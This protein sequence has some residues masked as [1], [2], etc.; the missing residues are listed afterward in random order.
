MQAVLGNDPEAD[1]PTTD[2]AMQRAIE[3]ARNVAD[4]KAT[5][6][7]QGEIGTGKARL[8][9]AIHAWSARR[10]G[11]LAIVSCDTPAGRCA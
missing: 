10:D 1:L 4:S 7:I 8:A 2:A 3:M 6:L 5:V 9:R 11:P